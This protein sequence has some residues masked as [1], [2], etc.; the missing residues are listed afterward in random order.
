VTRQI[1]TKAPAAM[2]TNKKRKLQTLEDML[3]RPWCYYCERDFDDTAILISH[4]KA[5]HFKCPNCPKRLSTAGGLMVH[6]QN[7]HKEQIDHIEN[8][9]PGREGVK[10]EIYGMI[11]VPE[12]L[13]EERRQ[14]A[15]R[16]YKRR[17]AQHI[18]ETGNPL[19][20]S[21]EAEQ[22]AK[23]VKVV[24]TKEEIRARVAERIAKN[25][26]EKEA[27]L[28]ASSPGN[29]AADATVRLPITL[30]T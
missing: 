12:D 28:L 30:Y 11:G 20:G 10:P 9:I 5:K 26:A 21:V 14:D 16:D 22:R 1:T 18:A 4:Q 13:V 19:A 3:E 17:E 25:K 6:V 2:A 23:R 29:G 7:V 24:E 8:A 27:K 15:I